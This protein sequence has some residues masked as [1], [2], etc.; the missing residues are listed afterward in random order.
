MPERALRGTLGLEARTG[1]DTASVISDL[2]PDVL[3]LAGTGSFW[4]D[5]L[6]LGSSGP[7]VVLLP[8]CGD[9]PVLSSAALRPL[10]A[11]ADA[12]GV[13]SAAEQRRVAEALTDP[14]SGSASSTRVQRLQVALP[15]NRLAAATAM[16][17]MAPFGRYLLV[18]SALPGDPVGGTTPPHDFLREV[19]GDVA[20][21]EVGAKNWVVTRGADRFE[22]TWTPSRMI[23]WRL[24][25]GA[26]VMLDLRAEGPVG[27]EAI[28][29]LCFGTPIVVPERS[30][31][32]EHAADSNGGLWYL[33][34][35]EM[36]DCVAALLSQTTLR[37]RLGG[38]GK[39]WA[40]QWHS[41]TARIRR[42]RAPARTGRLR[43]L[44]PAAAWRGDS[45]ARLPFPRPG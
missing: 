42:G 30:V 33:A 26:D 32:A 21:A 8:L 27:R 22:I 34:P 10:L 1:G 25:A 29:S 39:A 31:A 15:V 7:R 4:N 6:P 13:F 2:R 3:V 16:A 43:A 41:D 45:P 28:E 9:D 12:V 5:S 17:G 19:L 35:G 40:E 11:R 37:E 38:N 20:I 36:T 24:M 14:A 18:L 44:S 23:L